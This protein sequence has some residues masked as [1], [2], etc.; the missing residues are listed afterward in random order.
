ML[1]VL[2]TIANIWSIRLSSQIGGQWGEGLG[3]EFSTVQVQMIAFN[4]GMSCSICFQDVVGCPMLD[5]LWLVT[6][7]FQS[8]C[9]GMSIGT[10]TAE[11]LTNSVLL[12]NNVFRSS[13]ELHVP[14]ASVFLVPCCF[15]WFV[16]LVMKLWN[17]STKHTRWYIHVIGMALL[18]KEYSIHSCIF[19]MKVSDVRQ[20]WVT[21]QPVQRSP[22]MLWG[23]EGLACIWYRWNCIRVKGV[24][25]LMPWIIGGGNLNRYL[26]LFYLL[27]VHL[28]KII[29]FQISLI[30]SYNAL[31]GCCSTLLQVLRSY[32]TF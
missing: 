5:M 14:E 4:A 13:F 21:H 27:G 25:I 6:G 32:P 31:N 20:E 11:T 18:P 24:W 28:M 19:E 17:V 1:I 30:L 9:L 16:R 12:S 15:C 22:E 29:S 26:V 10:H 23:R 3:C 2:T 8:V 7:Y